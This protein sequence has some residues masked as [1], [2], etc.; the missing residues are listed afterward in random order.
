MRLHPTWWLAAAS[1]AVAACSGGGGGGSNSFQNVSGP[2]V[3]IQDFAFTPQ[4][5]TI[6]AGQSV[7]WTNTGP[8]VHDVTSDTMVFES[9]NM[10]VGGEGNPYGGSAQGGVFSFVF[11]TAGTYNYHCM[12]HPPS[13]Y[14]GFT[15]TIVVTQ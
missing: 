7:T 9:G 14:P 13:Q 11:P 3:T 12:L 4:T 5:I 1:L 10:A 15:G 8:S 6:K 2:R